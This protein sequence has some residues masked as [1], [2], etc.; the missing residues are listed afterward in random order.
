MRPSVLV[1]VFIA[2]VGAIAAGWI[3]QSKSKTTSL[4]PELEIPTDIDYFLAE[5]NYRIFNQAGSLDYQLQSPYLEHFIRDDVS[6]VRQPVVEV[7]RTAGDWR[8]NASRG[9]I[10]HQQNYLILSD[11]VVMQ[12]FGTRQL[13]VQAQSVLFKPD[14]NLLSSEENVIIESGNARISGNRAVFDLQNE[15]YSLKNTRSVFYHE[16]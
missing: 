3:Y 15:V 14:L 1:V 2:V 13:L 6:R 10:F 8:V 16:S 9:E 7:Y 5:L 4:R 12:K 11:D